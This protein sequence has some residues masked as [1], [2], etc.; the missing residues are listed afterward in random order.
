MRIARVAATPLNV[1][2][3]L[4]AAG[5]QK[6]VSFSV[7]LVEVE[8]DEGVIGHGFTAITEERG[9]RRRSERGRPR[10]A[11]RGRP[12]RARED[13]GEALL[14]AQPARPDR[15]CEPRHRRHRRGA[16]GPEGKG[17]RRTGLVAARRRAQQG[18]DLYD[19]RLRRLQPRRARRGGAVV[20]RARAPAPEDGGRPARAAAARRAAAASR[21]SSPRTRVACARCATPSAATSSC[22]STPTAASTASTPRASPRAL[23]EL[24]LS[25]FEE[26]V[27]DNDIPAASCS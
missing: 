18:A 3:S 8:A 22:T 20:D 10:R 17:A 21:R 14:A 6:R 27:K 25:F 23:E 26:P 19:L 1:P 13:L 11:D 4:D 16:L 15:L 5:I 24:E 9:R 2:V 7:C 12:A